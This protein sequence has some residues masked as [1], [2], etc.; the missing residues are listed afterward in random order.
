MS[1]TFQM[2]R[3][4]SIQMQIEFCRLGDHD[5]VNRKL[6]HWQAEYG[7]LFRK[8]RDVAAENKMQK[9]DLDSC[10]KKLERL[11]VLEKVFLR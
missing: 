5:G 6:H 3:V 7:I 9:R 11:K 2:V 10:Q 1:F 8:Y 4:M